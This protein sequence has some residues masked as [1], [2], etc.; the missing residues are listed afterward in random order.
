MEN[1]IHDYSKITAEEICDT[2][3]FTNDQFITWQRVNKTI[4]QQ[5]PTFLNKYKT[6]AEFEAAIHR[7]IGLPK[8]R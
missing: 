1:T 7:A 6:E 2:E 3:R 5:Q 4:V 8:E